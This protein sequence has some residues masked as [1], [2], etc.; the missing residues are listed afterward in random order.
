MRGRHTR[1]TLSITA[2]SARAAPAQ[3]GQVVPSAARDHVVDGGQREALVVEV[4]VQ[5]DEGSAAH[6]NPDRGAGPR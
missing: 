5:H 1:S 6:S 2:R 4:S 3:F